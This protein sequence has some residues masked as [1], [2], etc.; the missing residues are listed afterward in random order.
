MANHTPEPW[1][2]DGMCLMAGRDAVCWFGEPAQYAGD[3][4]SM[5]LNWQANAD[6][7]VACVNALRGLDVAKVEA[8]LHVIRSAGAHPDGVIV[9]GEY[10]D[11][12]DEHG[13]ALWVHVNALAD[14][15]RAG[16]GQ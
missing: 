4:P 9:D 5:C 16:G 14:A 6:R 8:L 12:W 11:R 10:I 13:E 7:V 2:L 3:M 15:I 1:T